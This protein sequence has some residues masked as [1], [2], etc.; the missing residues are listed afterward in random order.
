MS[1]HTA[2]AHW[3]Q[4]LNTIWHNHGHKYRRIW[5]DSLGRLGTAKRG[6]L[7]ELFLI[8]DASKPPE[9]SIYFPMQKLEKIFPSRS[10]LVNSP[11]ISLK[12]S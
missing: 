4:S 11:V 3:R 2:C 6:I 1:F 9:T 7:R 12:Q 8:L 10:S 5:W